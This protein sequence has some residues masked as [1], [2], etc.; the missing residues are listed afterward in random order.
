MINAVKQVTISTIEKHLLGKNPSVKGKGWKLS[1]VL[2]RGTAFFLE[3]EDKRE[4]KVG[5]LAHLREG[6]MELDSP[7]ANHK[8]KLELEEGY[9]LSV[10]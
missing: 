6:T 7:V 8:S 9:R 1:I 10:S 4:I 3:E 5:I 2:R